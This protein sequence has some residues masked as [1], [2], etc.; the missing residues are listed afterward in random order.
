MFCNTSCR[1]SLRLLET[2]T[3]RLSETI[4]PGI[5]IRNLQ[6]V[7][8]YHVCVLLATSER[9]SYP[10]ATCQHVLIYESDDRFD[11]IELY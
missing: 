10:V 7:S 6:Y 2:I 4:R 11:D 8:S 5:G 3:I 9:D 1:N